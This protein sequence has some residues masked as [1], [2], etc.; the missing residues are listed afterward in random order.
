MFVFAHFK[1]T[2]DHQAYA[3]SFL[4]I[5]ESFFALHLEILRILTRKRISTNSLVKELAVCL[6]HTSLPVQTI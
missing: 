2:L 6:I 4:H 5:L 1:T 3:T